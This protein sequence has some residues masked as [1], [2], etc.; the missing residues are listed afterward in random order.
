MISVQL[1]YEKECVKEENYNC[2]YE[3]TCG[4]IGV[5]EYKS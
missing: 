1:K 5:Y 3:F 2:T 4:R